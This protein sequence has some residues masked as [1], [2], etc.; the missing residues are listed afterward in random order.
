MIKTF[1]PEDEF[2]TVS[3]KLLIFFDLFPDEFFIDEGISPD[4]KLVEKVK[5][6]IRGFYKNRTSH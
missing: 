3:E 2:E 4:E 5:K 6:K 1:T